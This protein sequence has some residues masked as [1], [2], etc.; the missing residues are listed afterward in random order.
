MCCG[1]Q[2]PKAGDASPANLQPEIHNDNVAHSVPE[3]GSAGSVHPDLL[4][5]VLVIDFG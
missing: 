3:R 4:E 2:A 5:R 1:G